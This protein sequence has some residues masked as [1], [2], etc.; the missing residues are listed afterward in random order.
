[1][2]HLLTEKGPVDAGHHHLRIGRA[3][4]DRRLHRS[5]WFGQAHFTVQ[6]TVALGTE[7]FLIHTFIKIDPQLAVLEYR[8]AVELA[9][10]QV[11]TVM[12][13]E[14]LECGAGIT[15][16]TGLG[17]PGDAFVE[18]DPEKEGD[19]DLQVFLAGPDQAQILLPQ[20]V[21]AIVPETIAAEGWVVDARIRTTTLHDLDRAR[22]TGCDDSGDDHRHGFDQGTAGHDQEFS[23]ALRLS[24]GSLPVVRLNQRGSRVPGGQEESDPH[25][26]LHSERTPNFSQAR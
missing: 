5:I 3:D 10:D 8:V 2:V 16:R 23:F 25:A 11:S 14:V 13:T 9:V 6:E 26:P 19:E 24:D 12:T 15:K 4:L 17:E 22:G 20:R 21:V 18:F 7:G 1:M